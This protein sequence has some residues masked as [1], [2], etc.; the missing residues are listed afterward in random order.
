MKTLSTLDQLLSKYKVNY[1]V[2][3]IPLS[4]L[5][6]YNVNFCIKK[7]MSKLITLINSQITFIDSHY[8]NISKLKEELVTETGSS[9]I[10]VAHKCDEKNPLVAIASLIAY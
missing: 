9:N 2:E 10:I 4:E 3:T 7:R 8:Q 6:H 1:Y 5:D